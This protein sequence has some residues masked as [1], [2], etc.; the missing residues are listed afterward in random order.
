MHPCVYVYVYVYVCVCP[1]VFAEHRYYGAS[2]PYNWD[3]VSVR[4]HMRYLSAEQAMADYA[5][6]VTEI[7]QRYNAHEAPVIGKCERRLRTACA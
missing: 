1:Q 2:L 3:G 4:D 5:E 7:K 6:L